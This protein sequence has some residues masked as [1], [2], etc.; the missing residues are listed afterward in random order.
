MSNK[1]R[2]KP[3]VR[4]DQILIAAVELAKEV[5]YN[6]MTRDAI[7]IK[8][9]VSMGL[10]THY[11]ETMNQL[12]RDVMRYARKHEIPAIIAQGLVNNDQHARKAPPELKNKAAEL[13]ASL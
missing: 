7:A 4:K 1:K 3:D 5:G 12:R 8:A 2:Q 13:I 11:F 10:V 6:K 9:G